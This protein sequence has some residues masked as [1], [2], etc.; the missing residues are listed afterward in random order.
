M[1]IVTSLMHF[2]QIW[3]EGVNKKGWWQALE[4]MRDI[5]KAVAAD[6]KAHVE[7]AHLAEFEAASF[8]EAADNPD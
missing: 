3:D 4:M 8:I 7:A 2:A 6:L 1:L 5:N